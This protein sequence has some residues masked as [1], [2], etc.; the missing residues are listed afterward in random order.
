MTVRE[1]LQQKLQQRMAGYDETMLEQLA[2]QMDVLEQQK[3]SSLTKDFTETVSAIKERN[4][5]ED[6]D[7]LMRL[8]D[9]AVLDARR[10]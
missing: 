2:A 9:E 3:S 7:Q 6:Q 5:G 10:R 8:I 1:K 4:K